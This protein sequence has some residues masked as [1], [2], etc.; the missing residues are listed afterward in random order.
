MGIC[1]IFKSRCSSIVVIQKEIS[2]LSVQKIY[3]K[4][5]RKKVKVKEKKENISRQS[6]VK[7]KKNLIN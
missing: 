1:F 2:L 6:K 4:K 5:D 7:T 3:R